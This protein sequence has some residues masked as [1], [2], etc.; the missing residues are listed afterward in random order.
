MPDGRARDRDPIF[1]EPPPLVFAHRGGAREAPESTEAAFRHAL[2]VA[3]CDVLELDVQ[4]T[5][6]ERIVVWHGP[7][8]DNVRI[9]SSVDPRARKR[10]KITE[11]DWSELAGHAFVAHPGK[12]G[13]DLAKVPARPERRILRLEE[14]LERLPGIP[15]NIELK[16]SIKRRHLPRL[17][18]ILDT[19]GQ[20]RPILVVSASRRRI[21]QFRDLAGQS[22]ATGLS[23]RGLL[24]FVLDEL[25]PLP[26]EENVAGRAL[27]THHHR[28][29]AARWLIRRVKR[30][31]GAVHVFLTRF[32]PLKG[33]DAEPEGLTY[34]AVAEVLDRGV[35]GLMTDRPARLRPLV[36]EWRKRRAG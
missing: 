34:E 12:E 18:E 25:L 6:D 21:A 32:G 5:R 14:A 20:G 24:S 3:R 26:G 4:V 1:H 36:E 31:G 13:D 29:L 11:Y 7:K 27:Q 15:I 8:L 30:Q 10:R 17:L 22:Y 35:D 19:V 23:V 9:G 33:L 28:F 2:E 16:R